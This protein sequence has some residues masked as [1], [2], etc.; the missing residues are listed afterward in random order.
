MTG[1][2]EE[3]RQSAAAQQRR[4]L[5]HMTPEYSIWLVQYARILEYPLGAL[6]Y[7][8]HTDGTRVLPFTFSDDTEL[9]WIIPRDA[10]MVEE[11]RDSCSSGGESGVFGRLVGRLMGAGRWP[12]LAAI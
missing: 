7:G 3:G 2:H 1:R 4:G 9:P 12:A 11:N 8:A 6:I 10:V 5:K